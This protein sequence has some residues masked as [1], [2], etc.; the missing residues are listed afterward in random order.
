[1]NF[2]RVKTTVA[3]GVLAASMLLPGVTAL[4]APT[5]LDEVTHLG[6]SATDVI[7][8]NVITSEGVTFENESFVYSFAQGAKDSKD[9]D[10]TVNTTTAAIPDVTIGPKSSTDA[11][12]STDEDTNTVTY[13]LTAGVNLEALSTPG[14]YTYTV[15][16]QA[17]TAAT[18]DGTTWTYDTD[19]K[20]LMRV[21]VTK[22]GDGLDKN[23]TI[24]QLDESG[25]ET[26]NK[27]STATFNNK[28]QKTGDL[29]I[30]K[31][32]SDNTGL[33]PSGQTYEFKVTFTADGINTLPEAFVYKIGDMTSFG[34]EQSI[35]NGGTIK[36]TSG[37][38]ADFTN[39]P[40]GVKVTVEEINNPANIQET[41]I[42][43]SVDGTTLSPNGGVKAT[44]VENVLV[45]QEQTSISY[46]NTWRDLT[47]TGVV[48]DVAP[49]VTLVVVAVAAVA[50]YVVFKR[51]VAR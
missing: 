25:K 41:S 27:L 3:A 4:A 12:S 8:K 5:N 42:D 14:I 36:L 44:K 19:T 18:P 26:G 2:K 48:T 32:A 50:A 37:Q 40:A 29:R 15:S 35:V 1:M 9:G 45:G 31:Y 49:Y 24:V 33:E 51:R 22:N 17:R 6:G 7:T 28:L 16:E 10:Y 13:K 38:Q 23:I 43:Y 30:A 34:E 20:Y 21:Y 39:V 11:V 46:G 47:I